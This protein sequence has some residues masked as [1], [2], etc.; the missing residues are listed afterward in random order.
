MWGN[1]KIAF[2]SAWQ[3]EFQFDGDENTLAITQTDIAKQTYTIA[4]SIEETRSLHSFLTSILN[5]GA[6]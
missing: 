2:N 5:K 6:L 3:Y 1:M 4:L